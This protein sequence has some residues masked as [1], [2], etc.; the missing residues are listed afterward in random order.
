M[1]CERFRK[2]NIVAHDFECNAYSSRQNNAYK[3]TLHAERDLDVA[4]T[5]LKVYY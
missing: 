1:L 4:I 3:L 5:L 2:N